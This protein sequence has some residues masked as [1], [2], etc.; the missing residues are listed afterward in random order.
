MVAA[1]RI[2][3][4]TARLYDVVNR[5]RQLLRGRASTATDWRARA[6]AA[7]RALVL[8]RAG[9]RRSQ[10]EVARA[11]GTIAE[12]PAWLRSVIGGSAANDDAF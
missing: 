8:E 12:T 9:V 7:E 5:L 3:V 11:V 4:S 10:Q 1:M 6:L 2:A